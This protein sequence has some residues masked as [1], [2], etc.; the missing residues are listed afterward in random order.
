[1]IYFNIDKTNKIPIYKQIIEQV[2]DLIENES[3]NH[4]DL[5]PSEIQFEQIYHVSSFVVKRAYKHL[6]TH[7]Y[8]SRIKGKGTF[9]NSRTS[10][11]ANG[12]DL[13][14]ISTP[15]DK[16]IV[17]SVINI[18]YTQVDYKVERSLAVAHGVKLSSYK[19]IF[20][21]KGMPVAYAELYINKK[22]LFNMNV[23]SFSEKSLRH[24]LSNKLNSQIDAVSTLNAASADKISAELLNISL[25]DPL[26]VC[27]TTYFS[28]DKPIANIITLYP[29]DFTIIEAITT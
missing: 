15:V 2:I 27:D 29:G 14:T 24:I 18:D 19:A 1:M 28:K 9:V 3:I 13:D 8:I 23:L 22:T 20:I 17:V 7:G 12:F 11:I 16:A 26:I 4:Q 21:K 6:E 10:Y 5:L 25:G